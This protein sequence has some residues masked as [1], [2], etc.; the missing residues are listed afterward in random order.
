[1]VS[2]IIT[3]TWEFN[4]FHAHTML[5]ELSNVVYNVE[6]II[7]ATDQDGHGQQYFGN[8]GLSEPDPLTFVPFHQLTQYQVEKMVTEALGESTVTDLKQ[9]LASKVLEQISSVTATLPR[10]W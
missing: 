2:P 7:T 5:N 10:P 1:M 9:M 6:Y 8:V 3:Y 4:R